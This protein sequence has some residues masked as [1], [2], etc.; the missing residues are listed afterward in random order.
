MIYTS[1]MYH[2][3]DTP[4]KT[5]FYVEPTQFEA[6]MRAL[7]EAKVGSYILGEEGKNKYNCLLTFDDGHRS[8]LNV[9]RIMSEMGLTGYFFLVKDYSLNDPDYLNEDEI[10]EIASLGHV[11]GVHGKNHDEWTKLLNNNTLISQLKET[12]DWIEQLSGKQVNSCSAPGGFVNKRVIDSIRREIPE[13]KY[14][15]TSHYGINQEG[16]TIINCIGI[17]HDYS[18]EKVVRLAMN[19]SWEMKK[20]LLYYHVKESIKPLY[21]R[22]MKKI[23]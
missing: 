2:E 8:N 14:I 1:L 3:V 11:L 23:R 7:I 21:L 20:I 9:A 4:I 19:D 17:H 5:K 13:L 22:I 10:K 18:T 15:R 6:Q 16:D 12:K